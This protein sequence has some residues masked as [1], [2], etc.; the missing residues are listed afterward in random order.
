M[1]SDRLNPQAS[2]VEDIEIQ[3]WLDSLEYVL[4]R[5]SLDQAQKILAQLQIRAQEAGV[6]L[7]FTV[8]TPY[9]NTITRSKQPLYPGN[10]DLERQIKSIIRWNAMAMVVRGNHAEA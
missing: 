7:P 1:N 3:E 9:I 10:R 4:K 8:N 2:Q 6:T 5:G